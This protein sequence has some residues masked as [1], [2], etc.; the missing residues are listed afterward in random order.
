M[1]SQPIPI[2]RRE[3]LSKITDIRPLSQPPDNH[4]I[5]NMKLQAMAVEELCITIGS[6]PICEGG[7]GKFVKRSLDTLFALKT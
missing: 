2:G 7:L 3:L 1:K 4:K 5:L 6:I